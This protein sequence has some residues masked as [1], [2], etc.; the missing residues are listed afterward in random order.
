MILY[1]KK[2]KMDK[3][4]ILLIGAIIIIAYYLLMQWPPDSVPTTKEN[5]GSGVKIETPLNDLMIERDNI[6]MGLNDSEDILTPLESTP[7]SDTDIQESILKGSTLNELLYFENDVIKIGIDSF[8]GRFVSSEMKKIKITKGGENSLFIF[9]KRRLDTENLCEVSEGA[10]NSRGLCFGNYYASS[11]FFSRDGYINPN[12]K[13]L[14]KTALGSDKYLFVL[15]GESDYFSLVRKILIE[16]EEYSFSVEDIVGLKQGVEVTKNLIPYIEIV[17]DGLEGGLGGGRFESYTYTGP[18]FSTESDVYNKINFSDLSKEGFQEDSTGGWFALIQ[19]YFISAWVPESEGTYKFQAKKTSLNN[20]SLALTGESANVGRNS[21]LSFKNKL[22]VGPKIPE[23][24]NKLNPDLGL[25]ADYGFLW[26][27]AQPMYWLLG[28]GY[29]L[30]GNWGFAILFSTIIIRAVLWP[31]TAASYKSM[32]RMRTVA[33]Q[34]QSLQS[35]YGSDKTKLAQETMALYKK[36]GV[37]PLGG[38]LP[39]ALQMPFFIAFYWVLLDMVQLRHAPFIFWINDLSSKDPYYVLPV[40]NGALMYF[41]QKFMPVAQSTDPTQQQMQQM[42]KYMP[43]GICV[44]FA[45]FP[46]G[47]VLYFTAQTLVQLVQQAINFRKEG[48]TVRSV[49]FK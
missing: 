48:V 6:G 35:Q 2:T 18:V 30:L 20:Y 39:M 29:K 44:I 47:F 7:R 3:I 45:W 19:R 40:L 43:V 38:C 42:M 17:R 28:L 37:N 23:E 8:T 15:S 33:P 1:L 41:S 5:G 21:S 34:I 16:K 11:G 12:F 4:K 10:I 9:G 32:A 46:S 24:L 22:Y 26:F 14:Q 31:L 27:L 49:L 25:V 36:E 13:S